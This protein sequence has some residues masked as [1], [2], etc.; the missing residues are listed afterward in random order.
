MPSRQTSQS[1][2]FRSLVSGVA[3]G[4]LSKA[5]IAVFLRDHGRG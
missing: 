4:R 1:R 3:E 5:D 2:Q